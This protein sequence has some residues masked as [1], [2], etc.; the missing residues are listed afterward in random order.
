MP[1][2]KMVDNISLQFENF[3]CAQRSRQH[4]VIVDFRNLK[5]IEH[6]CMNTYSALP[7]VRNA[8]TLL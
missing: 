1:K 7:D 5:N 2:C 3:L 4:I 6:A 8:M